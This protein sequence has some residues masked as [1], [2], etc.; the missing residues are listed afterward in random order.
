ML[1]PYAAA[2]A[3]RMTAAATSMWSVGGGVPAVVGG[4]LFS[5][6]VSAAADVRAR[7]IS[8]EQIF[9]VVFFFPWF[10]DV[11]WSAV[12][13]SADEQSTSYAKECA[14]IAGYVVALATIGLGAGSV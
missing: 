1:A 11:L 12:H 3:A 6:A 9:L 14:A 4:V 2:R 7:V 8:L 5:E 10:A 13:L